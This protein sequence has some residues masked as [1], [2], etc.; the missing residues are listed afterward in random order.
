MNIKSLR[1]LVTRVSGSLRLRFGSGTALYGSS[2]EGGTRLLLLVTFAV[3]MTGIAGIFLSTRHDHP[4]YAREANGSSST[5]TVDPAVTSALSAMSSYL[6]T[7]QSFHV[8]AVTSTDDVLND[9]EKI[10]YNQA[11]DLKALKPDRLSVIVTGD[12]MHRLYLYNG[13]SFTMYG[14]SLNYYSTIPAP[15][16]IKDTADLLETKYG[17]QLPLVDLFHWG[18]A[19]AAGGQIT[20]AFDV[21]QETV[22]NAICEHYAFRQTGLDWQIWIQKGESPLP[23]R[24]VMTTTSDEARPQHE[25]LL[26]WDLSPTFE[27][28][29]FQFDPPA[30]A[31]KIKMSEVKTEK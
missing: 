22:A 26:T 3:L 18:T 9:G 20:S 15:A 27:P 4:V 30:S 7:L 10:Q 8:Q 12:D 29:T 24:I 1:E 11:V 6:R 5:A 31:R 23:L 2:R 25:A 17:L 21:G 16:T 28:T 13:T 14:K 19:S